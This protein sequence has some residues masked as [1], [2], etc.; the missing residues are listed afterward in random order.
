[1]EDDSTTPLVTR[2]PVVSDSRSNTPTDHHIFSRTSS[3]PQLMFPMT[4][5]GSQVDLN[6]LTGRL[7]LRRMR[8]RGVMDGVSVERW[9]GEMEGVGQGDDESNEETTGRMWFAT[10]S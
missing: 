8:G 5:C 4:L 3:T 7:E 2:N 1:M 10:V 9:F 6:E